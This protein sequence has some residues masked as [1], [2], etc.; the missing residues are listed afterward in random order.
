MGNKTPKSQKK[1]G[2]DQGRQNIP[3]HETET[4][5]SMRLTGKERQKL[6]VEG[7]VRENCSDLQILIPDALLKLFALFYIIPIDKWNTEIVSY[8]ISINEDRNMIETKNTGWNK[9]A[10]GNYIIKKGMINTWNL[11]LGADRQIYGTDTVAIL[12]GIMDKDKIKSNMSHFINPG[13]NG[14]AYYTHLS[15]IKHNGWESRWRRRYGEA[16][17][18]DAAVSMTLDMTQQKKE[19]GVLSYVINGTDYGVAFDTIDIDTEY[20][21]TIEIHSVG[22][23][24]ITEY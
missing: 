22:R 15:D 3:K 14:Y 17:Y 13:N 11:K 8:G 7:Y 24:E 12:I 5:K 6:C 9:H 19:N 4:S 16:C 1:S 20:C 18:Y 23:V 10:F 21:F 2:F